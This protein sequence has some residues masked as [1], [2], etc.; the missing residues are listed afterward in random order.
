MNNN[1]K[2]V[3]W[4]QY[5]GLGFQIVVTILIFLWLG[6]KLEDHFGINSP[7]GQLL[8]TFLGIF[9]SLYNVIR[10]VK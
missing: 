7:Y 10:T 4:M 1:K 5:S 2:P 3:N 9:A 8:G 6:T